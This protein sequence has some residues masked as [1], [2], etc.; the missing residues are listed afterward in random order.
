MDMETLAALAGNALVTAAVTDAFESARA[1]VARLFGRGEPDQAVERRL[2]ATARR[3][4]AVPEAELDQVRETLARQWETRFADLLADHPE[5]AGE[6]RAFVQESVTAGDAAGNVSNTV[7]GT[8][9]GP[10]LLGRDFGNVTIGGAE[11]G[12]GADA[13]G[14]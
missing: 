6:V 9:H 11:P 7:S 5:A 8:V 14:R 3:V 4:T 12:E 13:T 10:V 1:K 2:E